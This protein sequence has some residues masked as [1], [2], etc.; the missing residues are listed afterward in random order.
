[1]FF[2][3]NNDLPDIPNQ[4]LLEGGRINEKGVS[5]MLKYATANLLK[6]RDLLHILASHNEMYR[7]LTNSTC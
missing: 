7:N 6:Y 1:M 4:S 2:Q 5:P 3:S